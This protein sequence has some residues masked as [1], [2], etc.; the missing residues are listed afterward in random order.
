MAGV[1]E[2]GMQRVAL[3][4]AGLE[5]IQ[6]PG[7]GLAVANEAETGTFSGMRRDTCKRMTPTP[8]KSGSGSE[9]LRARTRA[10][11]GK[12]IAYR[13]DAARSRRWTSAT[14]T[15]NT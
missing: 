6:G 5:W 14:S 3:D 4:R 2:G 1:D 11:G 8:S 13:V 9:H 10:C 15:P 7:T 12:N